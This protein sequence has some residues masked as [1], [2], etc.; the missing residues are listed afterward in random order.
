MDNGVLYF[1]KVRPDLEFMN[2]I[3]T[4]DTRQMPSMSSEKLSQFCVA[5]SQF[6]IFLKSE[7]NSTHAEINMKN[8]FIEATVNMLITKEL[9][10]EHKSKSAAVEFL[11][12]NSTELSKV[13][14][15]IGALK[16]ELLLLEGQDKN[17]LELV[18]AFKRELTRREN[19]LYVT[20]V[21]R[22]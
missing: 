21:E 19:E 3:F 12:S 11:I 18:N 4:F 6:V 2:E 5:L 16:D 1:Q 14:D 20:R 15:Q 7:M 13:K 17:L 8:R 9:I 22:R 10:K